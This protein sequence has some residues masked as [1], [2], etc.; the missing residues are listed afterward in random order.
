MQIGYNGFALY[1]RSGGVRLS[2]RKEEVFEWLKKA[3]TPQSAA[4]L[5]EKMQMDRTNVSRYL[6]ELVKTGRVQKIDGRPVLFQVQAIKTKVATED[7]ITFDNLIG[8][9]DSLKS[10]IQ[11]SKAAILYPPRGL[12]TIIF[13]ETGTGKTMFA[14]CMYHFAVSSGMLDETAPFITF[15][16]ADY[17]QNPQ[18]LYGHIFGVK[19]GA[20]TGAEENREGLVA[21]ADGGILFLDEIHRLPP[22]GQEMLFTFIDK[23]IYR[24]LG[25]SKEKT[26]AVQILGATT[27]TSSTFLTTFNR[28][29]P[30]QIELP[31]LEQRSLDERLAIIKEFL[32]QEANRLNQEIAIDKKSLLAFLLYQAEG[33]IGQLKRDL[34]L[35]CAKTFLHYRTKNDGQ[36]LMIVQEDLPLSVQKGL[37]REKETPETI[38]PLMD[39]KNLYLSFKPGKEEVVWA[40]DPT[41]SMEVYNSIAHKLDHLNHENLSEIDLEELISNDVDRYFDTYV[42]ELSHTNAYRE[43]ISDELWHLTN[44]IYSIATEKLQR[45]FD[46]KV[47]FAFALHMNSTIER[48]RANQLI[49]HPNLNEIRRRYSKEFQLAIEISGQIEEAYH[50]MIPL[51]EIGFITMFLTKEISEKKMLAEKQVAVIVLMHGRST[52]SSMLETAQ[53][54]L[55]TQNGIAFNMPLTVKTE[56]MY[57][58]LRNYLAA[59]KENFSEG[60]ILLTDM[61]SLNDFGKLIYHETGIR[62]KVITLAS[63]LLVLETLR[64]ASLGRSL[65]DIYHSVMTMFVNLVQ[66]EELVKKDR[67]KVII[68]ACFTGEGVARKL[69]EVVSR[70]VDPAEF[71]IE[72]MQFL[73]KE[74]FKHRI[75]QLIDHKEIV[76]IVGTMEISYQQ[77]P[78]VPA[79]DLFDRKK[80]IAFQDLLGTQLTLTEMIKALTG[81]FSPELDVTEL[82]LTIEQ[83]LKRIRTQQTLVIDPNVLQGI[84]IHLAFLVDKIKKGEHSPAFNDCENYLTQQQGLLG[85]VMQLLT[86]LQEKFGVL[87]TPDDQAY[88]VKMLHDN[89]LNL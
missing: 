13:G 67:K 3:A 18:L 48:I 2:S 74:S 82:F 25:D 65:E 52:A 76:A 4:Q 89:D 26:A 81:D 77:I 46:E 58:Q 42:E 24:P 56:E 62:T 70:L 1:Q 68:V 57:T 47:R 44:E 55:G 60:I 59:S 61:G 88:L 14:E 54:L 31:S 19:R 21:K 35:V 40:Q 12:H 85:A 16:C 84:A 71:E 10:Q 8:R 27:E 78:F 17:A 32:Q 38:S 6:N 66:Q 36:K 23:G 79:L 28:R 53:D 86:Q 20:F 5:A 22:E 41:Q 73:E 15:N 34:K 50:V 11:K 33:N 64:L 63:T 87:F 37:L 9:E 49:P 29:I 30:M 45:Q 80:I 75:D 51:D 83:G 69:H 39:K 7:H 72:Q 43:I